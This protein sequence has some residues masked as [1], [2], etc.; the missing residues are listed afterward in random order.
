[1]GAEIV[2]GILSDRLRGKREVWGIGFLKV[3]AVVYKMEKGT[4]GGCNYKARNR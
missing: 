4:I 1:M 3:H 2:L